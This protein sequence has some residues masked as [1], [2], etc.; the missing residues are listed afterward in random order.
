M[1]QTH[2]AII[3]M[4][5][6][7][8]PCSVVGAEFGV[9]R[10]AVDQIWKRHA[11]DADKAALAATPT[12]VRRVRPHNPDREVLTTRLFIRVPDAT[13]AALFALSGKRGVTPSDLI[14]SLIEKEIAQ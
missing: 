11:T 5:R 6:T 1:D 9:S 7:G 12:A 4:R 10:Q 3:A 14:R 8:A 13:K 2:Q